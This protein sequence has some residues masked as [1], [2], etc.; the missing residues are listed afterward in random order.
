LLAKGLQNNVVRL[1]IMISCCSVLLVGMFNN[2]NKQQ[3]QEFLTSLLLCILSIEK[4]EASN[5]EMFLI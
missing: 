5:E 2:K 3:K 4:L 1:E